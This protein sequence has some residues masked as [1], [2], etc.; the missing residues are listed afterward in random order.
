MMQHRPNGATVGGAQYSPAPLATLISDVMEKVSVAMTK[1]ERRIS[2]AI[3]APH[4]MRPQAEIRKQ[5]SGRNG[6]SV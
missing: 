2:K 6:R 3:H 4:L 1:E 5:M